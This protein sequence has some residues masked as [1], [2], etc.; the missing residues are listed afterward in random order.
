MVGPW[1]SLLFLRVRVGVLLETTFRN[2]ESTSS[3]ASDKRTKHKTKDPQTFDEFTRKC[4]LPSTR[5]MN[6]GSIVF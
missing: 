3:P 1:C 6:R 4:H 2:T 5:E